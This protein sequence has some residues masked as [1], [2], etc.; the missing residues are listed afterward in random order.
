MNFLRLSN[1][2]GYFCR[3]KELVF[4]PNFMIDAKAALGEV[5]VERQIDDIKTG[6]IKGLLFYFF[7]Y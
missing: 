6:W 7:K 3:L 4:N 2:H 5:N 1:I